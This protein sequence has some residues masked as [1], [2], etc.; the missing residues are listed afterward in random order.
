MGKK[1][2]KIPSSQN[3]GRVTKT[4]APAGSVQ[5]VQQAE[6]LW[7]SGRKQHAKALL[8]QLLQNNPKDVHG[9]HLSAV[10][11]AESGDPQR[12]L[13]ILEKTIKLNQRDPN[14]WLTYGK[15]L[16]L[17]ELFEKA[18]AAFGKALKRQPNFPQANNG[19]GMALSGQERHEEA[20]KC[21]RTAIKQDERFALAYSNLGAA[22]LDMDKPEEAINPLKKAIE[23][24]P[25]DSS[26]YTNLGKTLIK[27]GDLDAAISRLSKAKEISP[28]D[29]ETNMA[30]AF[31]Y[32]RK[33]S[34]LDA[35]TYLR[36]S[37]DLLKKSGRYR[38]RDLR[39]VAFGLA[40]TL[41][42]LEKYDEAFA[43]Y[44]R[45]NAIL[46]HSFDR[47]A[48][49]PPF[50]SSAFQGRARQFLNRS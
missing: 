26:A 9:L 20:V 43:E 3:A 31:A 46:K 42:C 50:L 35:V 17:L 14:L 7:R 47:E 41:H 38:E 29:T 11:T 15:I 16:I 6:R 32:I 28:D 27:I 34:H 33:K 22:L 2:K 39:G 24:E 49:S 48:Q 12:A 25:K 19:L 23:I 8:N 4:T 10:F 44:E 45:G 37:N 13:D 21:Y 40:D 5:I 18:E 30:L 36:I 1:R